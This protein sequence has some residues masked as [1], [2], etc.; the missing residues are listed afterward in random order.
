MNLGIIRTIC[1][2]RVDAVTRI[3]NLVFGVELQ[4]QLAEILTLRRRA[5]D[6]RRAHHDRLTQRAVGGVVPV[7]APT[8]HHCVPSDWM[9]TPER[10]VVSELG[11]GPL[12]TTLL[13]T[14]SIKL[15]AA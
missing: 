2:H 15:P 14:P 6:M 3:G 5:Q 1:S 12:S 10:S 9:V 13:P 7:M 11:L 4:V 8:T